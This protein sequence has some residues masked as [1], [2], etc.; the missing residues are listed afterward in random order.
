MGTTVKYSVDSIPGYTFKWV[1]LE[2]EGEIIT[3]DVLSEVSIR[4]NSIQGG[5]VQVLINQDGGNCPAVFVESITPIASLDA[6]PVMIESS[7]DQPCVGQSVNYFVNIPD[8]EGQRTYSWYAFDVNRNPVPLGNTREISINLSDNAPKDIFVEVISSDGCRNWEG[9]RTITPVPFLPEGFLIRPN[10]NP[11]L[12]TPVIYEVDSIQ[13]EGIKYSWTFINGTDTTFTDTLNV[14]RREFDW[15]ISDS[16]QVIVTVSNGICKQQSLPLKLLPEPSIQ[17]T[18]SL[19]GNFNP[20]LNQELKYEIVGAANKEGFIYIWKF[21]DGELPDTTFTP[22]NNYTWTS[23]RSSEIEV[24]ILS[25]TCEGVFEKDVQPLDIII[26][27]AFTPNGDNLN[28]RFLAY[29]YSKVIEEITS[30]EII[31]RNSKGDVVYFENN[32]QKAFETGWEGRGYQAGTYL[33]TVKVTFED[34]AEP[35]IVNKPIQLILRKK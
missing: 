27:D 29:A 19:V 15:E 34:C 17:E 3:S 10:A 33:C 1:I 32:R 25:E 31:I 13:M 14:P 21:R 9:R 16:S 2:G 12:D 26:P 30:I 23:N 11:C 7:F 22:E 24:R 20:C 4:W 8:S 18:D 5:R 6:Q 28:D 35:I